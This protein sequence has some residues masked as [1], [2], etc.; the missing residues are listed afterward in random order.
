MLWLPAA[1]VDTVSDA[2]PLLSETLPSV[3]DPSRKTTVPVG[4]P[5]LDVLVAVSTTFAP[6]AA[7]L[8]EALNVVVVG[9]LA[10]GAEPPPELEPPQPPRSPN[11]GRRKREATTLDRKVIRSPPSC[12]LFRGDKHIPT[13]K[14]SSNAAPQQNLLAL[15]PL[16]TQPP[17][18]HFAA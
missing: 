2:V 10:G 9:T 1:R 12:N 4:L 6:S 5:E 13:L 11:T 18:C 16:R 17:F 8:G 15:K 3:V 7:G 14:A